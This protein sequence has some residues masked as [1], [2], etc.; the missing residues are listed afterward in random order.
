MNMLL[1]LLLIL[2]IEQEREREDRQ[3]GNQPWQWP[4][5]IPIGTR[6]ARSNRESS[7]HN[8]LLDNSPIISH[9]KIQGEQVEDFVAFLSFHF[10]AEVVHYCGLVGRERS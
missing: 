2:R 4:I 10:R 1:L 8:S 7:E 5:S 3:T 6:Q 9:L